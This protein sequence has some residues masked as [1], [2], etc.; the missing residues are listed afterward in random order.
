MAANGTAHPMPGLMENW[1]NHMAAVRNENDNYWLV[2]SHGDPMRRRVNPELLD[3]DSLREQMQPFCERPYGY[4]T[5]RLA[6]ISIMFMQTA[7]YKSAVDLGWSAQD[8][9]GIGRKSMRDAKP[10]GLM[11]TLA[12]SRLKG[13]IRGIDREG[14]KIAILRAD[15]MVS[16]MQTWR[17]HPCPGTVPF[18]ECEG[19]DLE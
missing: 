3:I 4:H 19:L 10:R 9:W 18:W 15:G 2:G 17:P 6:K 5:R 13:K 16:A 8:F 7:H 1:R 11:P 12:W 14:V